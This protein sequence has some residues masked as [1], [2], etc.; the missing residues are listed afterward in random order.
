[1]KLGRIISAAITL[2]VLLI[3]ACA[4]ANQPAQPGLADTS[5][6]LTTLGG[7]PILEGVITAEITAENTIGGSAGCNQYTANYDT[8]GSSLKFTPQVATTLMACPPPLMDIESRYL[9]A[10]QQTASYQ[11]D[12]TNLTLLDANGRELATFT[13]LQPVDLAGTNWQVVAYNNG[14]EAVISTLPE[15]PIIALFRKDG[16]MVGFTGC[17]TYSGNFI[18]DGFQINLQQIS[19]T[20]NSCPDAVMLQE[21]QFFSAFGLVGQ[22][23]VLGDQMEFRSS[24]GALA[25]ALERLPEIGLTDF[26]WVLQSYNNGQGALI[27]P[28]AATPIDL[29]MN[30]DGTYSGSSGCNQYNGQYESSESALSF[31]P[32]ATTRMACDENVM[33]AETTYLNLLTAIAGYEVQGNILLLRDASGQVTLI[34]RAALSQ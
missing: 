29:N 14:Q 12:G 30:S 13:K 25:M 19:Q 27:T 11:S 32:P 2:G 31:S 6:I 24:N 7:E 28:A 33:S 4:P 8:D 16:S 5:W 1:M 22:Y 9:E 3:T 15:Y 20:R 18:T 26:R 10:L 17:N 23:K 34:Y 21:A